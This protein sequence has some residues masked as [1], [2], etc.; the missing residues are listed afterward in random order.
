MNAELD[1]KSILGVVQRQ[2]WLIISVILIVLVI[3]T[4]GI[5]AVTPRYT[6]WALV[7]VDTKEKNLLDSNFVANNASTDN[8]RV[9][10]EVEIIKSPRVLVDVIRGQNLVSDPEFGVTVG[11]KDRIFSALRLPVEA[12]P[13]G[14]ALLTKIIKKLER[15][16]SVKRNGLTYLISVGVETEEPQ[17]AA[18]LTN[19]LVDSYILRQTS[20]KVSS[21]L[22]AR[23]TLQK[24]V[25]AANAEIADKERSFD[26]FIDEN[27]ARIENRSGGVSSIGLLRTQ[28][29]QIVQARQAEVA[30]MEAVNAAIRAQDFDKLTDTL[31]TEALVELQRQRDKLKESIAVAGEAGSTAIKLRE[32]LEKIDQSLQSQAET[33]L[34]ELHRSVATFDERGEALRQELRSTVLKSNLPADVLAEIYTLQKS[35]EVART[36]YQNLLS[37]L[38][39]LD[40]QIDLQLPDSRVISPALAP[41]DASFPN[42]QLVVAAA[43]ILALGLG[44]GLAILREYFIGGFV[45]ETQ[46]EAVMRTPL[47]GVAPRRASGEEASKTSGY[48]SVADIVVN[49][50]LSNF[51]ESIRRLRLALDQS[52][53]KAFPAPQG[54]EPRGRVVMVSSALPNEGKSTVAL[55]L[56]RAYA[57]SNQRV[58][59]IDFDLRKPSIHKHLNLE[60]KDD[61][62]NFLRE[63][64]SATGSLPLTTR[65]PLTNLTVLVGGGRTGIATDELIMGGNTSRLLA[66]ARRHFDYI[67]LD[68][69]PVEPVVDGLYL[70]RQTD[71]IVFVVKWATTPQTSAKRAVAALKQNKVGE[72]EIVSILN[73]KNLSALTSYSYS[74]YYSD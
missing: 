1:L 30:K 8:F 62:T 15:S 36:Q 52:E 18:L 9:E 48:H 51:S 64:V 57:L 49:L 39:D 50:P 2:I 40:A 7:L 41:I 46:F 68:S 21:T 44:M 69:P 72:A 55:S 29:E 59:L 38:Q 23:D 61:F 12:P 54:D 71:L 35:A 47:S 45:S 22:I 6:A 19:A 33:G 27:L 34:N 74:G 25:E 16:V 24:R 26:S 58:L 13:M 31:G 17:K 67:I 4:I 63:G 20:S 56:A 32:E 73:Q 28:L 70:A 3:A 14:D 43:L 42:T 53:R 60:A 37:R 5:F 66:N 65:D 10:S 11:L